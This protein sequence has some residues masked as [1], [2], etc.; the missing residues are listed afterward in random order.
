MCVDGRARGLP[1][2]IHAPILTFGLEP[3][4]HRRRLLPVAPVPRLLGADDERLVVHLGEPLAEDVVEAEEDVPV[5]VA[6]DVAVRLVALH[7]AGVQ[8]GPTAVAAL[9]QLGLH[10]RLRHRVVLLLLLAAGL[11][12]GLVLA[13]VVRLLLPR[14]LR[15]GGLGAV[16]V[17]ALPL[18]VADLGLLV[19]LLK[20]TMAM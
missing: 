1:H 6:H 15:A 13:F 20:K 11:L 2:S 14:P 7:V 18:L 19:V 10:F 16:L 4:R 17:L 3:E 12:A 9:A 8:G 5:V